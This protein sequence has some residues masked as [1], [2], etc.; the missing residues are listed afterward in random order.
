M[1]KAL[2]EAEAKVKSVGMKN[3]ES[4]TDKVED[5]VA[6]QEVEELKSQLRKQALGLAEKDKLIDSID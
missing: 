5:M 2:S 3:Q 1:Q 4:Q 6:K